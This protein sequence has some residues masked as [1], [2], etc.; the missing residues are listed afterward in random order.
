MFTGASA[1]GRGPLPRPWSGPGMNVAGIH[2]VQEGERR[3][4][5]RC[6]ADGPRIERGAAPSLEQ[7]RAGMASGPVPA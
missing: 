6:A 7:R 5:Q 1:P 3:Q 2:A 4:D